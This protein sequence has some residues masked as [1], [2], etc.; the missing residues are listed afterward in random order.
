MHVCAKSAASCTPTVVHCGGLSKE[1]GAPEQSNLTLVAVE[2]ARGDEGATGSVLGVANH[3][4]A[5][6]TEHF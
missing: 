4:E 2:G 6:S 1:E 5:A 3:N